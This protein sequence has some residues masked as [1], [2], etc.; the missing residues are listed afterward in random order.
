MN[1]PDHSTAGDDAA[2]LTGFSDEELA[3]AAAAGD[4]EA[5][6]QLMT[7]SAPVVLRFIPRLVDD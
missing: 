2:D 1:D 4:A 5:F 7:R 3:A 6:E